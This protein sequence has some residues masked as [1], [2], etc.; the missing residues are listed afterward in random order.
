MFGSVEIK[1]RPLKLAHLVDPGDPKPKAWKEDHLRPRPAKEIILGYIDAF[2]PDALVQHS[3]EIPE[4]IASCGVEVI[5]P[6][7]VDTL[8]GKSDRM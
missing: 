8:D 1:T 7:R 4:Y 3:S 2:D 6:N 5:R